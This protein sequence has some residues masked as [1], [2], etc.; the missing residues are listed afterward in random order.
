MI[1]RDIP[2]SVGSHFYTAH[3]G[4]LNKHF[5]TIN[6]IFRSPLDKNLVIMKIKQKRKKV[7]KVMHDFTKGQFR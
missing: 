1:F 4:D 3:R 7:K 6:A 5:P 2:V